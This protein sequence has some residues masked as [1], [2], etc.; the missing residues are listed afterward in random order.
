MVQ[1]RESKCFLKKGRAFDYFSGR[2]KFK[3]QT[4]KRPPKYNNYNLH[5][6]KVPAL[7]LLLLLLL[8]LYLKWKEAQQT[9]AFIATRFDRLANTEYKH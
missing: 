5:Y 6:F 3:T 2:L 9:C 1:I 7:L 4:A 8:S